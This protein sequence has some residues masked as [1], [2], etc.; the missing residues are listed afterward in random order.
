MWIPPIW[1]KFRYQGT[2]NGQSVEIYSN[3]LQKIRQTNAI[4]SKSH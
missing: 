4:S 1:E 3:F 2:V